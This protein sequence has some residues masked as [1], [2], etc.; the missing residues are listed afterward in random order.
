VKRVVFKFNS[1]IF[2]NV[3]ASFSNLVVHPLNENGWT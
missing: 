1:N 2:T 3:Q